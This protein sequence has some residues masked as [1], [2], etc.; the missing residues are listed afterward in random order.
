MSKTVWLDAPHLGDVEKKYLNEAVDSGYISTV[1][2]FV[3]EFEKKFSEYIGIGKATSVQ[4]GTAAIHIS[5]H[6]LGIGKDDEVIVPALTFIA[7]VNPIR[8]VGAIPV[9]ADVDR[10][11][12]NILPE[13]VERLVTERTKAIVPVHLYGNPCEMDA[14]MSIAAKHKLA[15]VEDA[16]E[17][18][19]AVYRGRKTGCHGDL[20]AFSF[21]GNKTITTGGGGMVVGRD[22][23]RI[24][25]IHF[26]AHQARDASKGYYHTEV[27]FNYRMTNI[28]AALGLAQMEKLDYFQER[29][30]RFYDIYR[31]ELNI[32]GIR[33]QK[34]YAEA[35]SSWWLT[36]VII[37]KEMDMSAFQKKLLE[38]G[39]QTRRLFMPIP[40]FPPYAQFEKGTYENT[41]YLYE[42]G[43]CLPSSTLNSDDDV[44]YACKKIKELL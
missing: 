32:A 22:E 42:H 27:G 29:K 17:S 11:T 16:T 14:I 15:V 9:F 43:L 13:A 6:E 5:L 8:Y 4:S 25:H 12:W 31:E 24:E 23:K 1:G 34:E 18:L 41:V 7:S 3:P 38:A 33:F 28:E 2:P 44:Y 21:N 30:K 36:S 37:D 40:D 39:I 26:L 19:G 10:E 20:A 35:T